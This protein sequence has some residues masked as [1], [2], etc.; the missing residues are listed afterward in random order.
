VLGPEAR[1]AGRVRD[2]NGRALAEVSIRVGAFERFAGAFTFSGLDGRFELAGLGVGRVRL[3]AEHAQLGSAETELE[4]RAGETTPW[5][6]TLVAVPSLTGHV[7]DAH[8]RPLAGLVVLALRPDD[9]EQRQRSNVTRDD[10]SFVVSDLADEPT[11][12]WVQAALGW[13]E[14]PLLEVEGVRPGGAPLELRVPDAAESGRITAEIVAAD[15]TVL[16]GAELQVWHVERRT[17]R[18]F[19]SDGDSGAVTIERVPPGTVELELR[20]PT[21]AWKHLGS[22]TVEAGATLELGRVAFEPAGRLRVR[23]TGI[24]EERCA[25]LAAALSETTTSR[26]SGV[27]R[28]GPGELTAGPLAAGEHVLILGGDG[29]RQ[30]RRS[31]QIEADAETSFT[32]ALEPCGSREVVLV[33]PEGAPRPP[34]MNASVYDTGGALLWGGPVDC[35]GETLHVRVSTPPGTHRLVLRGGGLGAESELLV[36]VDG[37]TMPPFTVTLQRVP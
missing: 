24:P 11:L 30:V 14:F 6:V 18:S 17:Y 1:V 35:A 23:I 28:L 37:L 7:L 10:G 31:F 15:G 5:D 16:P 2:A 25:S 12:V 29:V 33:L 32:L 4:L 19:V 22:R 27:A 26:E 21:Q 3:V 36:P 20:H 9:H 8:G 13:R 34:W